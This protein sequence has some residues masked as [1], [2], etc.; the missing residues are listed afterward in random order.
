[1]E[2]RDEDIIIVV[3]TTRVA[4]RETALGRQRTVVDRSLCLSPGRRRNESPI[5]RLHPV[6]SSSTTDVIT[7]NSIAL[8]LNWNTYV[9]VGVI[10]YDRI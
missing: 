9:H 6:I 3:L 4:L 5:S 8:A 1:M 2:S 10:Q 7:N